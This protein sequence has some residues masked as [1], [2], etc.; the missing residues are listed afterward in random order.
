MN[1]YEL[2]RK[3]EEQAVLW[4]YS[5]PIQDIFGDESQVHYFLKHFPSYKFLRENPNP[6]NNLSVRQ[7]V[8]IYKKEHNK[9]VLL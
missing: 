8:K 1:E 3:L 4:W 2:K 9:R 7:I 5:L 6:W